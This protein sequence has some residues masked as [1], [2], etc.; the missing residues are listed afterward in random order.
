MW[1]DE[2]QPMD[3]SVLLYEALS[4]NEGEFEEIDVSDLDAAY[5]PPPRAKPRRLK[6]N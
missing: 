2:E 5:A 3:A 6:L 1:R 4:R